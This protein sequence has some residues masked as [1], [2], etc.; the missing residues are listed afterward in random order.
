M[1]PDVSPELPSEREEVTEMYDET[2]ADDAVAGVDEQ[3]EALTDGPVDTDT[4][5]ADAPAE[6]GTAEA[7]S[8]L[9]PETVET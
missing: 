2:S 1:S 5:P 6:S 3:Q 4:M 9:A 7:P 8:Y